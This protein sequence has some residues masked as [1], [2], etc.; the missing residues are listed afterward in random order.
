MLLKSIKGTSSFCGFSTGNID[1]AKHRKYVWYC[2]NE[3]YSMYLTN[4]EY[5][6]IPLSLYAFLDTTQ[7]YQILIIPLWL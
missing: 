7:V 1:R 4:I 6:T 2:L 3:E 5:R